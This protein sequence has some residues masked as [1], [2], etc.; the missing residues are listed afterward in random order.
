VVQRLKL[1]T[2]GERVKPGKRNTRGDQVGNVE[3]GTKKVEQGSK[4]GQK[5]QKLGQ[6]E[7]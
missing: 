5:K 4:K 2:E 1:T 3:F 6:R 7:R